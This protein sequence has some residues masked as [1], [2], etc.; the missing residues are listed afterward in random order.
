MDNRCFPVF[1][2]SSPNITLKNFRMLEKQGKS[3]FDLSETDFLPWKTFEGFL[4]RFP[5][6]KLGLRKVEN[7][8]GLLFE[9][10]ETF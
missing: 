2:D 10:T 5:R 7:P 8:F 1:D 3:V 9:D 6:K 4:S